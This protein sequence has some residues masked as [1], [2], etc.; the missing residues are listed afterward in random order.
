MNPIAMIAFTDDH[1]APRGFAAGHDH[2][3][4][5]SRGGTSQKASA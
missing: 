1:F 2:R 5:D 3:R 4:R